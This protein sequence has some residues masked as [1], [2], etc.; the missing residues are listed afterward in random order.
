MGLEM[1]LHSLCLVMFL[2][3][4]C[5]GGIRGYEVVW[6]D[7][8]AL[9][10]DLDYCESMNIESVVAWPMVGRF[11]ARGGVADCYIVPIAGTTKSGMK[12]FQWTR[13]FADGL[14]RWERCPD[15]PS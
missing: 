1:P 15:W 12:F 2:L 10:Y 13:R 3:V 6:T 11:K 7:L 8:G 4:S 9:N 5:L 14:T